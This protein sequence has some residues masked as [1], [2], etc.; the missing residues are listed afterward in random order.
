MS[1]KHKKH[2]GE[3]KAEE[4]PYK[5]LRGFLGD[6]ES[7]N[8]LVHI[9]DQIDTRFEVGAIAKKAA[10][11]FH[12]SPGIYYHDLKDFP[13]W[14]L[15]TNVMSNWNR[16]FRIMGS[17]Q[18][19]V[20]DDFA[21]RTEDISLSMQDKYYTIEKDGD[22]EE[23]NFEGEDVDIT[24]IPAP[25]WSEYDGG[26]YLT[27]GLIT[28]QNFETG[29]QNMSIA[30][31][32]IQSPNQTGI[33]ITHRQDIGKNFLSHK[34]KERSM[35]I[36]VAIG[37]DPLM[38]LSSQINAPRD[39]SEFAYAGALAG[40]KVQ[41]TRCMNSDLLVPKSA[42]IVLEGEILL[43]EFHSEGPFGEFPGF[44][45]GRRD[46]HVFKVKRLAM[47]EDAIYPGMGVGKDPNE[48]NLITAFGSNLSFMK[49]ARTHFS[50][51]SGI[52]SISGIGFT[53]VVAVDHKK[54]Y[55]G[56]GKAAGH[57]VWSSPQVA[58]EAKNIIVVDDTID[59]YSDID[60]F[61][62]IGNYV[63]GNKDIS[64]VEGTPG[65]ILD[66][67]EPWGMGYIEEDKTLQTTTVTII[68]ATPKYG[69][70]SEGY[71]RGVVD[72]PEEVKKK[73]EEKW[74]EWGLDKYGV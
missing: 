41:M 33:L 65:T 48:G 73:I 23:L 43:D 67:S 40:E 2:G 55:P 54:A 13:D 46:L 38:H 52:R 21:E 31:L 53:T 70:F 42:E 45:S 62:A 25:L 14:T 68:D 71:K 47:K 36:A 37:V 8:E 64:V 24:M 57:F 44:Y 22:F 72:F 60:I 29:K 34:I 18:E 9:K 74:S 19:T 12:K 50:E 1:G 69:M 10:S 15:V 51:I 20:F 5:S 58:K 49:Y 39:L 16:L 30:R 11:S 27:T 66:P 3:F 7:R 6:M 56:I 35:P 28:S 4:F 17:T 59:I 63:Q 32:M 26:R 61:W